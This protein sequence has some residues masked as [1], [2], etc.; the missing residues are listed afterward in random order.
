[1]RF[2]GEFF[3]RTQRINF[4]SLQFVSHG[5]AITIAILNAIPSPYSPPP[6]ILGAPHR[7]NYKARLILTGNRAIE[8]ANFP[9]YVAHGDEGNENTN[10]LALHVPFF[11]CILHKYDQGLKWISP[12]ANNDHRLF[13][14]SI[15]I[16]TAGQLDQVA[17]IVAIYDACMANQFSQN[18]ELNRRLRNVWRF[19]SNF[20]F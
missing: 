18:V 6:F 14:P 5:G 9:I 16:R 4:P 19:A 3:C 7:A 1:M 17:W 11:K 20:F 8:R 10:M 15:I 12:P 13:M 2:R